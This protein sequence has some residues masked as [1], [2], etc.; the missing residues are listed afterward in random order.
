MKTTSILLIVLSILQIVSAQEKR[1]KVE[2]L[3][4]YGKMIVELY[5][6]TPKHRDN[7]IKLVS[8][9]YYDGLLFHR[10]IKDFM[11]QGG[12]TNSRNAKPEDQLGNGGPGYTIDAELKPELFHKKGALAAARLGD[13]INP[14]RASSGSQFYIVQGKK[15]TPQQIEAMETRI[16]QSQLQS[17]M[18]DYMLKHPEFDQKIRAWQA[19]EQHDSVDILYQKIWETVKKLPE[20]KPFK[21]TEQQ[22]QIYQTLG[23]TPHLDGGYTVFGEVVEGLNVI[24]SIASQPTKPGDRPVKDIWMKIKVLP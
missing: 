11:I 5:N 19:A 3:T 18:R 24:D 17:L 10:V 21:Y 22:K 20:A 14:Q 6:E 13:N 9:G 8:E 4:P 12:D 7:F 16:N 23:G 1:K 2:I 15:F